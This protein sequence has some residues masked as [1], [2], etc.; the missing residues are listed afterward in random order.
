MIGKVCTFLFYSFLIMAVGCGSRTEVTQQ[1]SASAQQSPSPQQSAPPAPA[2]SS[3]APGE[4]MTNTNAE[5]AATS[6]KFDACALITS[7]EIQ[8]IQGE[9][10][11]ATKGSDRSSGAFAISQCF[12]TLATFVKSISL[13]VTQPNPAYKGK[14]GPKEFWKERFHKKS[15]DKKEEREEEERRE[16]EGGKGREEEEEKESPPQPVPGVGE[17]AFWLGNN[18]AGALYVLK[19]NAIVRISIG[20]SEGAP[21]KINKSKMLAQKALKRL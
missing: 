7:P 10:V 21:A 19:N 6:A 11:K 5:T 1:S 9:P 15:A 14:G 3:N 2:T 20:G 17:E 4:Q 18:K 12:Y 13:E 16:K 8:E